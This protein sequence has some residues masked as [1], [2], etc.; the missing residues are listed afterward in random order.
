MSVR[1]A[2]LHPDLTEAQGTHFTEGATATHD[3]GSVDLLPA[4]DADGEVADAGG[5]APDVVERGHGEVAA[6]RQR[7]A[8][9]TKQGQ[10]LVTAVL[11]TFKATECALPDTVD[12]VDAIGLS[13]DVFKGD[14]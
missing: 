3:D 5:P 2:L 7:D 4:A 14:L 9:A 11:A 8:H 6:P 10:E 13:Q 12:G 1:L